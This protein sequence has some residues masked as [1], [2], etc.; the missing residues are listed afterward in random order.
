MSKT[1]PPTYMLPRSSY[2][3]VNPQLSADE[4]VYVEKI[5][6]GGS[7]IKV[8]ERS[9]PLGKSYDNVS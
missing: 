1:I 4:P 8:F 6:I 7:M 5:K 2:V 9:Y 3:A